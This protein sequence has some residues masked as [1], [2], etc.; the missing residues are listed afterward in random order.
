MLIRTYG[1]FWNPDVVD[2]GRI[3]AGNEAQM[4]GHTKYQNRRI[5][6]NAFRGTGIYV[7]FNNFEVIYIGKASSANTSVGTRVRDHLTDRFEG[8]WDSFSFYLTNRVNQTSEKLAPAPGQ[9]Q[10]SSNE[11]SSTLE[12]L[13]ID[14]ANP[15]LNRKRETIKD[16]TKL[17]QAQTRPQRTNIEYLEELSQKVTNLERLLKGSAGE[18]ASES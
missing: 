6:V 14:L 17:E 18:S 8:R 13:L 16:A 4:V 10:T 12:S 2:W 15:P 9:K 5:N 11:I 7:L 1:T 3:G